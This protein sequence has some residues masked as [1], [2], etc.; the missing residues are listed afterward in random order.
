MHKIYLDYAAATPLDCR[1]LKVMEPYF[2]KTFYNPSSIYS[3]AL[4]AKSAL[5]SARHKT[6]VLIGARPSEIIFTSGGT[7]SA[8]LA[9]NGVMKK[10]TG[11][12]LIISSIE[13]EAV[14][15][16]AKNYDFKLVKVN[17]KGRVFPENIEDL[18]D[19]NTVLVSIMLAN[20]EIGTVQPIKEVS[21]IINNLRQNRKRTGNKKPLYFHVDACQAP[22][23][24]DVDV[25]RLGVDMMTLN[26]GK[27]YG[28]KQ[29]GILYIRTGT[30]IAPQILGGGQEFGL[31]SGTENVANNIG[32]TKALELATRSRNSRSRDIIKI[33]EYFI[34]KLETKLNAEITGD[35]KHRL[36]NNVHAI[37]QNT[38]NERIMFTLDNQ[39]IYVA[40]GSACSA[41]KDEPSHVLLAIGKTRKE[42]QSSLRFSL[43]NETTIEQVDKTIEAL[44]SALK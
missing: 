16:P 41:S 28:P 43:G 6:A 25:S 1:V 38:D 23:Y 14:L 36:A 2:S 19:E 34:E 39:G 17:N 29:S 26:G 37:F 11:S 4:E 13:H 10:H 18:C 42:A 20:N 44:K 40:T 8:N 15:K 9:I 3:G 35:K 30:V 27:I 33:R 12:N 7:E 5:E 31:R 21:K 32:F 22:L 24:L